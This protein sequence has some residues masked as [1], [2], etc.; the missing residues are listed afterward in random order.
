MA[1]VDNYSLWLYDLL[2][3]YRLTTAIHIVSV[4]YILTTV[5]FEWRLK[6]PV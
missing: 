4:F 6:I 3:L 1:S 2:T 5:N